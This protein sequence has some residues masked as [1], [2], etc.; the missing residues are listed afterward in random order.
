MN[1]HVRMNV[2]FL[3]SVWSCCVT[4]CFVVFS[5]LRFILFFSNVYSVGR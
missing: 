1:F 5:F 2:S 4:V 3:F